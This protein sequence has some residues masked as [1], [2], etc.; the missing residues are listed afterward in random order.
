MV[1]TQL[2]PKKDE[3]KNLKLPIFLYLA[4]QFLIQEDFTRRQSD[5]CARTKVQTGLALEVALTYPP[6]DR[7]S[8]FNNFK[9]YFLQNSAVDTAQLAVTP[10]WHRRQ[11]SIQL[12]H[13]RNRLG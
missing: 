6:A 9:C 2:Q 4:I 8:D 12:S 7:G 1:S 10:V 5:R 11:R 13:S 3:D